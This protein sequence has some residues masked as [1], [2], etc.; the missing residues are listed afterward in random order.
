[1]RTGRAD[2]Y[3]LFCH[4]DIYIYICICIYTCIHI[5][6]IYI[7]IYIYNTYIYIYLRS[8]VKQMMPVDQ[9]WLSF[10]S[11]GLHRA[12]SHTHT[13]T[14][15]SVSCAGG[16]ALVT[17]ITRVMTILMIGMIDYARYHNYT[18]VLVPILIILGIILRRS[19]IMLCQGPASS[20]GRG[21]TNSSA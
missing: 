16:D 20:S 1:M 8:A 9:R 11:F 18:M 13:P 7:Y 3:G 15:T 5:L 4:A 2:S 19:I 14:Y 10:T 17:T 12:L 21:R 6:Y